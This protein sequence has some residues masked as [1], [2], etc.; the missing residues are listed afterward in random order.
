MRV[1][2]NGGIVPEDVARR[3]VAMARLNGFLPPEPKDKPK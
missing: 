2:S 1:H 3:I